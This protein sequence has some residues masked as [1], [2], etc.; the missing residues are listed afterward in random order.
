[1]ARGLGIFVLWIQSRSALDDT[2]RGEA[3]FRLR[4]AGGEPDWPLTAIR[5]MGATLAGL[6]RAWLYI[7]SGRLWSSVIAHAVAHGALGV[8]VVC[9]RQ[10]QFW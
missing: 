6:A 1:M 10:G 4:P 5:W 3:N 9:P 8:W 7:R 2:G